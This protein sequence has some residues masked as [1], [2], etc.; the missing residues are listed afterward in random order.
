MVQAIIQSGL[1]NITSYP[2]LVQSSKMI[3]ISTQHYVPKEKVVKS[4][5]REID[6]DLRL[7]NIEKVF[8]LPRE[9]QY[10]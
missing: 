3:M 10:L 6:L 8:Y 4:V 9:D 2:I 5:T 7:E 1:V